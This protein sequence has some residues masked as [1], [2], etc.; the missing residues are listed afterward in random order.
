MTMAERILWF[1]LKGRQLL[2]YK[3]RRQHGIS[4]YVVDF[5]CPDLKL[6][7]EADGASH[8]TGAAKRRDVL[9]QREIE[10]EG[11]RFLRFKDEEILGNA[12]EV[13]ERI[14]REMK[15]M[16]A[17]K[18]HHPLPPPRGGGER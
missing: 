6:A 9:R 12:D 16:G 14:G 1:N 2:G 3:I 11:V 17:R 5:Y 13:M 8:G 7:I 15:R 10:K 18:G 4:K